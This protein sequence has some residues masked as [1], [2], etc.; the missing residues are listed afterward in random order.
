MSLRVV[1][2]SSTN[3]FDKGEL[4]IAENPPTLT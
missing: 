2:A 4:L 1:T 3:A